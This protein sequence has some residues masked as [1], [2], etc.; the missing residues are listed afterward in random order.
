MFEHIFSLGNICN[1]RCYHSVYNILRPSEVVAV[2]S[3]CTVESSFSKAHSGLLE[4]R[5]RQFGGYKMFLN[6]IQARK[7]INNVDA[8]VKD[9]QI[10]D[11]RSV[12]NNLLQTTLLKNV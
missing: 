3:K 5:S 11:Q 4:K 2:N 7:G 9:C 12:L 10:G 6:R 8:I 1:V